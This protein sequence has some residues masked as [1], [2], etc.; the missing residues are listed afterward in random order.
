M[1]NSTYGAFHLGENNYK[2]NQ[3]L[4]KVLAKNWFREEKND[5]KNASSLKQEIGLNISYINSEYIKHYK[6]SGSSKIGL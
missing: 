5:N 4:Q 3:L 6:F 1:K 2:V